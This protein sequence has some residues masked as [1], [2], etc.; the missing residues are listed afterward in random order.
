M[1]TVIAIIPA[2]YAS[3]RLPGKP[4]VEIAGRSMIQHVY[5]RTARARRIDRV[6]VATDDERIL[7]HVTAFGGEGMMTSPEHLSGTDRI[8]EA[9]R[10][11]LGD[12]VAANIV[13]NVQGDEPLVDPE[14]IDRLVEELESKGCDAATPV[15]RLTSSRELF[16]TNVVKVVMRGDFTP[17]YFSRSP[18][19][20]LRDIPPEEWLKI[21]TFYRHIG[22]YAYRHDALERFIQAA[23]TPLEITEQLEQLRLLDMAASMICVETDYQG[24]A[25]DTAEDVMRVE[26]LMAEMREEGTKGT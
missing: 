10:A 14:M 1:A 25:V 13:V 26:A 16:D 9:A 23:P 24:C 11:Y 4:L 19:P 17:L 21:A 22:I 2:R 3:T 7:E 20:C 15:V 5:E 18:I 8:G 12:A 6:L